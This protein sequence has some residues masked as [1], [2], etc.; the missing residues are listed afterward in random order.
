MIGNAS[1]E[2]LRN[3]VLTASPEQLLLM[4]YDGGIRFARQGIEGLEQKDFEKSYNGFSRAQKI[5]LELVSSL[6]FDVDR[7]L[8]QKMAGLYNFIYRSLVQAST[9]RD[10][11]A[12]Q[13]A[14]N[15]LNYQRETWLLLI[16]K[17]RQEQAAD[18]PAQMIA[19]GAR[20]GA[21]ASAER[22]AAM[23]AGASGAEVGAG[24]SAEQEYGTVNFE[25]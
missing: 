16:E 8:C 18:R 3:A 12:A 13:E 2:Y 4:L 19:A 7:D 5:V 1:D 25:G 11:K 21:G 20:A 24:I 22:A 17:V 10:L 14:L 9:Q 15:V 6:N 23:V